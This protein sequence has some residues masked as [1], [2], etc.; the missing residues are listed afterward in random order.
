MRCQYATLARYNPLSLESDGSVTPTGS[1]VKDEWGPVR[2]AT[3]RIVPVRGR[4]VSRNRVVALIAGLVAVALGYLTLYAAWKAFGLW[5]LL[6]ADPEWRELATRVNAEERARALEQFRAR[7]WTYTFIA[8][9]SAVGA[10]TAIGLMA[11]QQ[12]GNTRQASGE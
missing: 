7:S 5:T 4:Q 10:S 12:P 6:A 11:R 3:Q 8:L 2:I 9:A 1:F